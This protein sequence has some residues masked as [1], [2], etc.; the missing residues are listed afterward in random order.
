MLN[1]N[2]ILA[3]FFQ[4]TKIELVFFSGWFDSL[5]IGPSLTVFFN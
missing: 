5:I 2:G 4:K 3:M 1:F